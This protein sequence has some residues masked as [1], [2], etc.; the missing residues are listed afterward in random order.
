VYVQV[1]YNSCNT[2]ISISVRVSTSWQIS[3]TSSNVKTTTHSLVQCRHVER[4]HVNRR[5]LSL[6]SSKRHEIHSDTLSPV[7]LQLCTHALDIAQYL[8]VLPLELCIENGNS[9]FVFSRGN[10][11]T[12]LYKV[13]DTVPPIHAVSYHVA[14]DKVPS[15]GGKFRSIFSDNGWGQVRSKPKG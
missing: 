11:T 7:L 6:C 4:S 2:S 5:Q 15:N 3:F 10:T 9:L 1:W 13:P 8:L 14:T 12:D